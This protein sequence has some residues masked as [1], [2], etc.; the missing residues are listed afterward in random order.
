MVLREVLSQVRERTE[1][2]IKRELSG[3]GGLFKRPIYNSRMPLHVL[4]S[5]DDQRYELVFLHDG[6]VELRDSSSS[7]PDVIIASDTQTL[8]RLFLKPSADEFELL[9][10]QGKVKITAVS[11]KGREAESYMRSFL[12]V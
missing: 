1:E 9:E 7:R 11:Q 5:T 3:F 12:G 10:R 6:N 8:Q 4:V 2:R